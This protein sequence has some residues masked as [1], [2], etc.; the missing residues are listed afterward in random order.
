MPIRS[1]P[2]ELDMS[3][4]LSLSSCSAIP[5][6]LRTQ[7]PM[8]TEHRNCGELS[9]TVFQSLLHGVWVPAFAG[10]TIEFVGTANTVTRRSTRDCFGRDGV[11]GSHELYR[12][13]RNNLVYCVS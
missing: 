6:S 11:C 9:H 12:H 4:V 1:G 7:G 3:G 10:T 13:D 5:S 8:A 2:C